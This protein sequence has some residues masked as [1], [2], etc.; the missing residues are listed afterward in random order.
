MNNPAEP[1]LTRASQLLWNPIPKP[2]RLIAQ[3]AKKWLTLELDRDLRLL[4]D[5]NNGRNKYPAGTLFRV[6]KI[7]TL[8]VRLLEHGRPECDTISW[9][10]PWREQFEKVR[11]KPARK[12]AAAKRAATED[13]P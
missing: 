13:K 9:R 3:P 4:A 6:T 1:N 2:A 8:G 7:T 5:W 10:H 11:K 12:K